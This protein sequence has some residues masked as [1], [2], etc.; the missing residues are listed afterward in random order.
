MYK[1]KIP[2]IVKMVSN[3]QELIVCPNFSGQPGQM[4]P[5]FRKVLR[6]KCTRENSYKLKA[7]IFIRER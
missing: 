5:F 7:Y 6:E 3:F 1:K 4:I 2:E